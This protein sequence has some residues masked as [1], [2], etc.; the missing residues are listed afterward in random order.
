MITL[1]ARFIF[2]IVFDN[3][4]TAISLKLNH[5]ISHFLLSLSIS[6]DARQDDRRGFR[7]TKIGIPVSIK[8][9]ASCC[10]VTC[11]WVNVLLFLVLISMSLLLSLY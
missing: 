4:L 3:F 2:L 5:Q 6:S 7:M 8:F 9:K 1:Y 10:P 11:P